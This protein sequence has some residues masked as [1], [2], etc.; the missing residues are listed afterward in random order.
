MNSF[1]II[2]NPKIRIVEAQNDIMAM[3]VEKRPHI[4]RR[5]I[6]AGSSKFIELPAGIKRPAKQSVN[7][8]N[9]GHISKVRVIYKRI[10]A[11]NF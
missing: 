7:L 5:C 3:C 8:H 2:V 6:I 9:P 1:V 10:F 4:K 11:F